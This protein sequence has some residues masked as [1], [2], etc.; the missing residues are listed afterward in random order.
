[1]LCISLRFFMGSLFLEHIVTIQDESLYIHENSA[2]YFDEK[3][4]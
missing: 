2:Y 1:M 3:H 4:N